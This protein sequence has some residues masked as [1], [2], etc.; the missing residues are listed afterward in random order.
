[1]LRILDRRLSADEAAAI[2]Q[3]RYEPPFDLYDGSG[4]EA[5]GPLL[6]R[7]GQGY[8]YY[9]V[10]AAG[11]LVGFVCFGPEARVSGQAEELG[12]C[13]VGAGLRPDRLSA[14][15]GTELLPLALRF[16]AER[17]A[18]ERARVAIAAFNDR[19]RRLCTAAGFT[20]V[21]EFEGPAGRPFVEL[22][23]PLSR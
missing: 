22:T 1:V 18:A 16:A 8:G 20:L 6:H 11:E 5:V 10:E 23:R 19:S 9:P 17:F 4:P 3:W 7:D 21:R 12:T 14:R 15:V 2:A 13:D